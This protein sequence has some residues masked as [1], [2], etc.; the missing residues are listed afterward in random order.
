MQFDVSKVDIKKAEVPHEIFLFN[1]VGNHIL[2][3][4]ASLGMFRSFPYPLYL[5]PIISVACLVYTILR[6]KR[7]LAI[8]PWFAFCHWQIAARRAKVF[9]GMLFL[10]SIFSLFGWLGYFYFDLMKEAIY[11]II[12]GIGI[13]P[14]MVTMLI[15]IMVESDG[16]YQANQ[17]RLPEWVL[18]KFPQT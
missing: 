1:L 2:I 3:F 16:L 14:T 8:D 15:L 11:A 9:I 7:S 13:L 17:R 5:V 6:A 12:G 4:I 18:R 10:L